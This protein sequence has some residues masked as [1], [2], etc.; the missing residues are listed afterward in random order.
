MIVDDLPSNPEYLDSSFGA[1]AGLRDFD[2]E[3]LED[4][5]EGEILTSYS[6]PGDPGIIS[7]IGGETIKMLQPEGIKIVENY[8]NHLPAMS[9]ES[10][11]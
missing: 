1:A 6:A 7:N 5:D 8:F 10:P 9:E 11:R 2:D 4:F 3:D